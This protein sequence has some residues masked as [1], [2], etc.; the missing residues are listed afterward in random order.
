[1]GTRDALLN[2]QLQNLEVIIQVKCL[3]REVERTDERHLTVLNNPDLQHL[4]YG[5]ERM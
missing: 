2:T 3:W 4:V 1:M 5:V